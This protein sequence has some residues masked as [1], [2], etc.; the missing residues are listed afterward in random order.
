MNYADTS[1]QEH[2]QL[3][4]LLRAQQLDAAITLLQQHIQQAGELLV[5]H[6]RAE[7]AEND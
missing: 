2:W 6:L 5:A 7:T 4:E 1:H 3:L